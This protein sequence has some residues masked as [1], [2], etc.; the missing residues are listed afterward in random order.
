M[1]IVYTLSCPN[2]SPILAHIPKVRLLNHFPSAGSHVAKYRPCRVLLN[3]VIS[4]L[5]SGEA[6]QRT[7][8]LDLICA[9]VQQE[10]VSC[11]G[12][13]SKDQASS[14]MAWSMPRW[15]PKEKGSS[16]GMGQGMWRDTEYL[17]MHSTSVKWYQTLWY[18]QWVSCSNQPRFHG[19]W[20]DQKS[21]KTW[22]N[23]HPLTHSIA[24]RVV[25]Q[26]SLSKQLHS[27]ACIQ[28]RSAIRTHKCTS[29]QWAWLNKGHSIRLHRTNVI[30]EARQ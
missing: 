7:V 12:P 4:Y 19:A 14:S 21:A 18:Q 9:V 22:Q 13:G 17:T 2:T 29:S 27:V 26:R 20:T 28:D 1:P 15:W 11:F 25:V 16:R 6:S 8:S 30:V 3:S 10:T 5:L 24:R 23:G